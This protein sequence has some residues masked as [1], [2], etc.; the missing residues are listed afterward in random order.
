MAVTS[1]PFVHLSRPLAPMA[2]GIQN[3][4]APLTVNI[5]PQVRDFQTGARA[6]YELVPNTNIATRLSYL[7]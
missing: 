6:H 5:Q 4:I 1:E 7:S 2:V 3:N